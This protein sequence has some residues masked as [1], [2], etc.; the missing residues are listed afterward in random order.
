MIRQTFP[1]SHTKIDGGAKKSFAHLEC[2]WHDCKELY[3]GVEGW[4]DSRGSDSWI[5][6]SKSDL[7]E[8]L[9]KGS[10]KKLEA[11]VKTSEK[12]LAAIDMGSYVQQTVA[13]P[14]G[15]SP[16]VPAYIQGHPMSMYSRERAVDNSITGAIR[17]FCDTASIASV[18][19][20]DMR[21][22][23]EAVAAMVLALQS[24]RPVEVY[25]CVIAGDDYIKD[26]TSLV[27]VRLGTRPINQARIMAALAEPSFARRF[28]YTVCQKIGQK[29]KWDSDVEIGTLSGM[30]PSS[31]PRY[32][33]MGPTDIHI[34]Y[35]AR[36]EVNEIRNDA[37][38]WVKK[39]LEASLK[40]EGNAWK[41]DK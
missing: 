2:E 10:Y 14:C 26:V 4:D 8:Y 21:R 28:L 25:A 19:T 6:G 5:G 32:I 1:K 22:R 41:I 34:G 33:G 39:H 12:I 27:S 36:D 31:I 17:I 30:P 16:I 23:G 13:G 3:A 18:S 11:S 15:F 7:A 37:V 24:I 20:E 35:L 29:H 9:D 40:G 38:G